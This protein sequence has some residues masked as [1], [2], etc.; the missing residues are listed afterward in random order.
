MLPKGKME[1][2]PTPIPGAEVDP[3]SGEKHVHLTHLKQSLTGVKVEKP[4]SLRSS[5][6]SLPG[7]LG[8]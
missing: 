4:Q 2:E 7:T 5:H 3:V 1:P 6:H 8:C